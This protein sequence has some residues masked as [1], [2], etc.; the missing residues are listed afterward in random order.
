M[1]PPIIRATCA[2]DSKIRGF[3]GESVFVSAC[4]EGNKNFFRKIEIFQFLLS[5]FAENRGDFR[6]VLRIEY[7]V[8]RI[9]HLVLKGLSVSFV[10]LRSKPE[11]M[12]KSKMKM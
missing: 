10:F 12:Q 5:F 2:F 3:S 1:C 8:S 9:A 6:E 4:M 11:I 7:R